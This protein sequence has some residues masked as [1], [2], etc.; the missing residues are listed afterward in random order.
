LGVLTQASGERIASRSFHG[1]GVLLDDGGPD[2]ANVG[3]ATQDRNE[4]GLAVACVFDLSNKSIQP[5][6]DSR[7]GVLH[8]LRVFQHPE[9]LVGILHGFLLWVVGFGSAGSLRGWGT[10]EGEKREGHQRRC[11]PQR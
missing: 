9:A 1:K 5:K 11:H 4:V 6:P 7:G 2:G 8:S 3:V 10:P